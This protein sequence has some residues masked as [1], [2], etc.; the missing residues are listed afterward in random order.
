[1]L[2]DYFTCMYTSLPSPSPTNILYRYEE[3]YTKEPPYFNEDSYVP[4]VI[5]FSY[6][7]VVH[8]VLFCFVLLCYYPC[9][10]QIIQA[11]LLS[12][13]SLPVSLCNSI[14]RNCPTSVPYHHKVLLS[15]IILFSLYLFVSITYFLHLVLGYPMV[16]K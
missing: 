10:H 4:F 13:R 14:S 9:T 5:A 2:I 3:E 11:L 16:H 6:M 15:T 8:V 1:M 7:C 12:T